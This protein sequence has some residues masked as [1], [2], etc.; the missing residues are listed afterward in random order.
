MPKPAEVLLNV[1]TLSSRDQEEGF[2]HDLQ[3]GSFEERVSS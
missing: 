2:I 3:P 1:Q